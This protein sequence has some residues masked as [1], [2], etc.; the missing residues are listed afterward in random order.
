MKK[1][2]TL[3]LALSVA[4]GGFAQVKSMSS[5]DVKSAQKRVAPRMEASFENVQ[6]QSNM[7]RTDGELDFTTY[8][9][10]SNAAA[11]TWTKVWNDGKISFAY[12]IAT[13]AGFADRGT[14]IGTYDAVNDE[15]ISVGSRVEDTKTGFGTIAQFG[16]NSLVVAAHTATQ[17]GLWL[18]EDKD[19]ITPEGAT[20][21][22]WLD[23][24]GDPCWPNVMTS[25]PNRNIIHVLATAYGV[26]A[27]PLWYFRSTDGGYTW[28]KVNEVI[29]FLS[30][31]YGSDWGSNIAYWMET[32]EDNCLAFVVSNAWSD[33]MVVYSYDD[34]E[35]WERKVFWHHPGVNT[36]FGENVFL[37]PRWTS[38]QWNSNKELML[39]YE[40][41][42][43]TGA[44]GSGSYYPGIGGVAFWS[45][46]MP[47]RSTVEPAY[48]FD[49]TN[50]MAPVQ[51]QPFIMDSAYIYQDIYG[52]WPLFSDQT[53]D[54][55]PEYMGY[56]P[57]LTDEGEWESWE[58]ATAFNIEDRS[59]HGKYNNGPV[60]FPVLC[61]VNGSDSDLV[62]VWAAL[63]ENNTDEV[64]NYFFKI[65]ASMSE[66]GGLTWCDMKHITNSFEYTYLENA[67]LQAAV[68]NNTL[69]VVSQAD[70]QTGTFVQGDETEGDDCY[71]QGYTFDLT[72]LFGYDAVGE[73]V[74]NNTHMSIYPNPA[75]D[76]LNVSLNQSASI[77]VYNSIGQVI[78][79]QEGRVGANTVDLS[80]LN[81]GIYF[82]SAGSDTQKFIV[83]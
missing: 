41:N 26:D 54:M 15:W 81:A 49:P 57:A 74:S 53:H 9:W 13:D 25:G 47:Y 48:G 67:Y 16:S 4:A 46:Y 1:L 31:Q 80:G 64:G 71:Y 40:F 24:T 68:V 70:Y 14:G 21:L 73:Q 19:N 76:Q 72:E 82:I 56:L 34:G 50:P 33:C 51:G 2:F 79:T 37:Y 6:S 35:T 5:K 65:F 3:A 45:E 12:T 27:N 75:V 28:D 10:Q 20:H 66:D 43:S 77:V 17:C 42:G 22:S 83:K 59:L 61:K 58:D 18:V 69:V 36:D 62:A 55:L 29:P 8:D 44:P 39:A 23:P 52:S 38:A 78:R 11:R 32:T 7:T 30:E 60:S 63:D